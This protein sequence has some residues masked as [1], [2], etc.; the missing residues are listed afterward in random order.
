MKATKTKIYTKK[1]DAGQT[2][3]LGGERVDKA[4]PRLEAY[5]T[6]DELN[7]Y[8]GLVR[9]FAIDIP[10]KR[11]LLSIQEQLFTA[12]SIL[13]A[14]N[15]KVLSKIPSINKDD[16]LAL[17]REIDRMCEKIP[18]QKQ[19][20]LPGGHPIISYCHIA[21]C[22]CRRAERAIARL[23]LLEKK[24]RLTLTYV[25]RLSDYLFVLARFLAAEL[26]I[27]ENFLENTK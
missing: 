14:G 3:L 12:G 13:A 7:S 9:D 8:I 16:L 17:E 5:G 21:R 10:V 25:N 19:F 27:K 2:S 4:D 22:I 24:Q 20:I 23:D 26:G 1:G 15:D 6:L 11:F 18:P